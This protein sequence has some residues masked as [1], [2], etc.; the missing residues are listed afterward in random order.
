M[1]LLIF[2]AGIGTVVINV[3]CLL[4]Q[5][6]RRKI[7]QLVVNQGIMLDQFE[8][9]LDEGIAFRQKNSADLFFISNQ[10]GLVRSNGRY[11]VIRTGH[12]MKL[13]IDKVQ[14]GQIQTERMHCLMKDGT[15]YTVAMA[16]QTAMNIAEY[17]KATL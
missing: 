7:Q 16:N 4:L 10:Y 13:G 11:H 3:I 1:Y 17:I 2:I 14:T 9:N 6:D 15:V 5:T 8:N 12:I